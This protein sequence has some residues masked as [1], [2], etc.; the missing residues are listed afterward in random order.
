VDVPVG[1][2]QRYEVTFH[3]GHPEKSLPEFLVYGGTQYDKPAWKGTVTTKSGEVTS[4]TYT[5]LPLPGSQLRLAFGP[6]KGVADYAGCAIRGIEIATGPDRVDAHQGRVVIA[7]TISGVVRELSTDAR[8]VLAEYPV[9]GVRDV[10]VL[11]DGTI[12]ALREDSVVRVEAKRFI[13]VLTG[14]SAAKRLSIERATGDL[15]VA[16]GG[17]SQQIKRFGADYHLKAA[18]GRKGGRREGLYEAQDFREVSSLSADG[19]GGFVITEANSAPRRTAHFDRDGN[20]IRE[21]YGGQLWATNAAADPRDDTRVWF[22][23]HWGWI[24]EAEVDWKNRDWRPR[25]TYKYGGLAKGLVKGAT[26]MRGFFEIVYRDG[27]KHLAGTGQSPC[28]LRV[29]EAERRLTPV[30]TSG[31]NITHYWTSQPPFLQ[32]LLESPKS[33]HKSYLWQ[34]ANGDGEPQD[35]EIRFSDWSSWGPGWTVSSKLSFAAL[36]GQRQ[37]D[38]TAHLLAPE[39]GG[40]PSIEEA[41]RLPLAVDASLCDAGQLQ[42]PKDAWR[43]T[44]GNWH[45]MLEGRGDGFTSTDTYGK[46]HATAWPAN[47]SAS[48]SVAKWDAHGKLMWKVGSKA[49]SRDEQRRGQLHAG[50]GTWRSQRLRRR[51]GPHCSTRGILDQRR[52]LCRRPL[53]SP[54]RRWTSSRLL[55]VVAS[56][57]QRGAQTR[58]RKPG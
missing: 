21:W 31:L 44:A 18:Y 47:L 58:K 37:T 24:V 2:W 46:G 29:D 53:R 35:A 28:L 39:P 15:L 23:S 52:A 57:P 14:L 48:A 32:N 5:V 12:L 40:Y 42:A 19:K 51:G 43:D 34:D 17:E 36:Y 27:K 3:L 9:S 30:M 11:A 4:V 7:S 49:S 45:A 25:S 1:G 16:E 26:G 6:R 22:N 50:P 13:P 41:S 38:L 10:A 54:R 33:K 55:C 56:R 8:E 20:L